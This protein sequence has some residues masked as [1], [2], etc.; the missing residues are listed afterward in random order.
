MRF[1]HHR[2]PLNWPVCVCAR[3]C[4]CVYVCINLDIRFPCGWFRT[5]TY[6][7]TH[8]AASHTHTHTHIYTQRQAWGRAD[9]QNTHTH[10]LFSENVYEGRR[11]RMWDSLNDLGQES[12]TSSQYCNESH[13]VH[14]LPDNPV[15]QRLLCNW[16]T[17]VLK[18]YCKYLI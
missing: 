8:A 1:E 15:P 12:L 14:F 4:D 2:W 10:T 17:L 16:M 3:A 6:M 13:Y 5:H 18:S 7:H 11:A 9:Q